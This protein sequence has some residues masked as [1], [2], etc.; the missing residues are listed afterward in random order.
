[1]KMQSRLGC[2]HNK[3]MWPT[4]KQKLQGGLGAYLSRSLSSLWLFGMSI[5]MDLTFLNFLNFIFT[6]DWSRPPMFSM[7]TWLMFISFS[8]VSFFTQ[9]LDQ[10]KS[11]S[12]YDLLNFGVLL[13]YG[14]ILTLISSHFFYNS[15]TPILPVNIVQRQPHLE[16]DTTRPRSMIIRKVSAVPRRT[17]FTPD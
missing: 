11:L 10:E 12:Y 14:R 6:W 5:G 16:K 3:V 4:K 17:R 9:S 1:M 13:I 8:Y 2:L 15:T 7:F